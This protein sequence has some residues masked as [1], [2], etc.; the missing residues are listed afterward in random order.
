M[1]MWILL[2]WINTASS[3]L[4]PWH[5]LH[6]F[7]TNTS[8]HIYSSIHRHWWWIHANTVMLFLILW[9]MEARRFL[10]LNKHHSLLL[11]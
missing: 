3:F 11:C 7:I 6:H 9:M 4:K 1:M 10:L 5:S 8:S 2:R